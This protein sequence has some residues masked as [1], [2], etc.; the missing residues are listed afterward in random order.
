L[1]QRHPQ[2]AKKL[3]LID[4]S[5][6]WQSIDDTAAFLCNLDLIIAADVM[7]AHLA[8]AL[9]LPTWVLVDINPFYSWGAP[10]YGRTTPWYPSVTVYR[11]QQFRDWTS[12][13][14]EVRKDLAELIARVIK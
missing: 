5:D 8:G 10:A 2:E 3:G 7:V 11:Q 13:F 6:E 12:V 1:Q 4:Y 9:K 14:E